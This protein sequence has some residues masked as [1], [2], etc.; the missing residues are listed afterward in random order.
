VPPPA[1]HP[2]E[3]HEGSVSGRLNWLRAGVLGAN[4]GIVSTAGIVVGVAGATDDR[5]AILVAGIAGLF[6]GALSM[7][8]GEYVSVST[9]RD[10]EQA[11]LAKERREL[12]EEPEEELAEL[13]YLYELKGLNP[14]LAMQVATELTARDALAAHAEVELG[15]DP[16]NLTNPWHAAGAS[17]LAFTVGALLPLLTISLSS[18]D[19]RLAVTVVSVMIALALTGFA[20][21]RLGEAPQGRA[22]LRNV[23]GG[24]LAMSVT[25][26]IG[27]AVGSR[28]G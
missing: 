22:V 5:H 19:T 12:L 7:G 13:A 16:D 4:D 20:S 24:L 3:P 2:D 18:A 1:Q 15:I 21:A 28:L 11:L 25:H 14:D 17:M 9:Q 27:L 10:T 26:L 8:T 23:A 6:A